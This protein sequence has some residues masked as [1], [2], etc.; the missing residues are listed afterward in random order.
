MKKLSRVKERE[1]KVTLLHTRERYLGG[2][3]DHQK[4]LYHS[5]KLASKSPIERKKPVCM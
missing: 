1:M 2:F 3:L 5:P 4:Q